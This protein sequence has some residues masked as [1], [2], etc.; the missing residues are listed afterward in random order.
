MA[1]TLLAAVQSYLSDTD[2][3]EVD[4]IFDGVEAQQA[5]SIAID[6]LNRLMVDINYAQYRTKLY[7]LH[8][9][10]D[11][12]RPTFL[13]IPEEVHRIQESHIDYNCVTA[14]EVANGTTVRWQR[15]T[16]LEPVD[17]LNTVGSTTQGTNTVAVT[18][19][20]G[21]TFNIPNNRAPRYLTS[22]DGETVVFDSY[23]AE[24]DDTLKSSKTRVV[25]SV[26]VTAEMSDEYV[27]PL[28]EHL[29]Y[30][31]LD[32]FKSEASE[33]LRDEPMPSAAR[34]ARAFLIKQ[35]TDANRVGM[36]PVRSKTYGRK[37]RANYGRPQN[38]DQDT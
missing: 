18:G 17:F 15:M 4:S 36:H 31:W 13:M 27:I 3:W 5:A 6:T 34:R 12:A 33:V 28:P 37:G 26:M 23:D 10:D 35:R 21:V 38:I 16:Y 9:I 8:D 22:F 32:M 25:A 2:G 29:L 20:S 19:V 11:L 14:N 7:Q 1:M 30:G 24:V